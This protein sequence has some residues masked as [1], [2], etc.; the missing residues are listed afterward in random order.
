[1]TS[2]KTSATRRYDWTS[3]SGRA[4]PFVPACA[5]VEAAVVRAIGPCIGAAAMWLDTLKG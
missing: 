2:W 4:L 1:M 5:G 3:A